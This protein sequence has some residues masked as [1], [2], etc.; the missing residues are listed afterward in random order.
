MGCPPGIMVQKSSHPWPQP[1]LTAAVV[2][3]TGDFYSPTYPR[4]SCQVSSLQTWKRVVEKSMKFQVCSNIL[5]LIKM[6]LQIPNWLFS[7]FM[8]VLLLRLVKHNMQTMMKN[9]SLSVLL[10]PKSQGLKTRSIT[11]LSV[12]TGAGASS[13]VPTPELYFEP[14]PTGRSFLPTSALHN[15]TPSFLVHFLCVTPRFKGQN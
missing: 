7:K 11:W 14:L 13:Q 1:P 3:E 10:C 8:S 2:D 5:L 15:P 12:Q 4:A 9:M 6:C